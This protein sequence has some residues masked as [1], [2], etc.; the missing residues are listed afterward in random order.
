M[1]KPSHKMKAL[2]VN[3]SEEVREILSG[4]LK[5]RGIQV[6]VAGNAGPAMDRLV[7]ES[8]DF[9]VTD[10]DAPGTN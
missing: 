5:R 10:L 6:V 2:V 3:D 4:I 9:V 7:D 1:Q 8:F